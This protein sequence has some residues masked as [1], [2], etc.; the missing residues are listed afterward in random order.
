MGNVNQIQN[1]QTTQNPNSLLISSQKIYPI[2]F[3]TLT[4]NSEFVFRKDNEL[5]SF[6]C[7]SNRN[8]KEINICKE[9]HSKNFRIIL[10]SHQDLQLILYSLSDSKIY[11]LDIFNDQKER[12]HT[13]IN[14]EIYSENVEQIFK[15][16]QKLYVIKYAQIFIFNLSDQKIEMEYELNNYFLSS[17]LLISSN[18]AYNPYSTFWIDLHDENKMKNLIDLGINRKFIDISHDGN[19]LL[20]YEGAKNIGNIFQMTNLRNITVESFNTPIKVFQGSGKVQKIHFSSNSQMVLFLSIID[21]NY[22][23]FVYSLE[24]MKLIS[25][26][27]IGMISIGGGGDYLGSCGID[28]YNINDIIVITNNQISGSYL[29]CVYHVKFPS[30][31]QKNEFIQFEDVEFYFQ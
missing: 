24:K 10:Y 25:S 13:L 16:K 14:L 30:K 7:L 27:N 8:I 22:F 18:F 5:L 12:L 2:E 17:N 29:H 23:I 3:W 20:T 6:L 15:F 1:F 26:L 28:F 21:G 4:H 9:L 11:I 19:L 31:L